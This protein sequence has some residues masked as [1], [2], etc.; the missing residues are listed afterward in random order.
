MNHQGSA[1]INSSYA[2]LY[3]S[4]IGPF[5]Y[6]NTSAIG[7]WNRYMAHRNI[8]FPGTNLRAHNHHSGNQFLAHL[9][10]GLNIKIGNYILRPF[11]S[12]DYIGQ[13]EKQ[14]REHGAGPFDLIVQGKSFRM[15]RNE[16]GLNFARCYCFDAGKLTVDAKLGWVYEGRFKGEST[17]CHFEG[18]STN[19]TVYSFYKNRNAVST[20]LTVSFKNDLLDVTGYYDGVFT[21]RYWD[22]NVGLQ[23]GF[24]F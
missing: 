8:V 7:S 14:Y 1:G 6:V 12:F 2:G 13:Q 23:L 22:Q 17:T 4:A 18:T 20:G 24:D 3:F 16:F 19:F 21:S 11:D 5:F 9:D 10:T 15:I